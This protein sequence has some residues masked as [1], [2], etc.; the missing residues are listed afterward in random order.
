MQNDQRIRRFKRAHITRN[1]ALMENERMPE[2]LVTY[3]VNPSKQPN[4]PKV[5]SEATKATFA[6]HE[7]LVKAGV[8]KHSWGTGPGEGVMV[9]VLPSF[10][11]AYKMGNRFWPAMSMEIQELIAWDKVEEIVLSLQKEA[12]EL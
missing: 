10:E 9:M 6:A 3:K 4:D 12:A 11:E 1:N 8:I 5:Q 2:Y 7:G